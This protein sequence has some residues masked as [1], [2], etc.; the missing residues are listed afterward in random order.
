MLLKVGGGNL[1]LGVPSLPHR[2][3]TSHQPLDDPVR[4]RGGGDR[5]PGGLLQLGSLDRLRDGHRARR[6]VNSVLAVE[7]EQLTRAWWR[8]E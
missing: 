7:Q 8:C 1:Q 5:D 2:R 4:C 3:G 6:R